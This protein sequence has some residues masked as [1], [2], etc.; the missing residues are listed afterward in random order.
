MALAPTSV[1]MVVRAPVTPK[2]NAENTLPKIVL[3]AL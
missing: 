1:A 3:T 2:R